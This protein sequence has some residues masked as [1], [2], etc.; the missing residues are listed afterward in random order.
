MDSDEPGQV[1]DLRP[2]VLAPPLSQLASHVAIPRTEV[3][4][5]HRLRVEPCSA[6]W[7]STS[8]SPARR[9]VGCQLA[10]SDAVRRIVPSTNAM[11]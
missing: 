9:G 6:T 7:V 10:A 5:A 3:P 8:E 4:D 1:S 2:L 11:A